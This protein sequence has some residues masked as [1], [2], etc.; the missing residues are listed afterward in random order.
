MLKWDEQAGLARMWNRAE[1]T[2]PQFPMNSKSGFHMQGRWLGRA[3]HQSQTHG[4][5]LMSLDIPVLSYG[6]SE[7]WEAMNGASGMP[8]LSR[9]DLSAEEEDSWLV[10]RCTRLA[11]HFVAGAM[12]AC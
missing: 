8:H 10:G 1:I 12:Q 6:W 5:D 9:S 11:R 2:Y 4:G 3:V 7:T